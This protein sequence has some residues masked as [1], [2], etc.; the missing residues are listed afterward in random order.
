MACSGNLFLASVFDFHKNLLTI[1]QFGIPDFMK[2]YVFNLHEKTV[3]E[4]E[5]AFKNK[6]M[7]QSLYNSFNNIFQGCVNRELNSEN[8]TTDPDKFFSILKSFFEIDYKPSCKEWLIAI[9][10][11]YSIA[12][13]RNLNSRIA[14]A[15][16]FSTHQYDF[17][18]VI[19]G[20]NFCLDL[21]NGFDHHELIRKLSKLFK[22]S[23]KIQII[24]NPIQ[25]YCSMCTKYVKW[26]EC[27]NFL[28][29]ISDFI[30]NIILAYKLDLIFFRHYVVRFED[31]KLQTKETLLSLCDIIDIEWDDILLIAT[32]N[33]G[34]MVGVSGTKNYDTAPVKK[35]YLDFFSPFDWFR[36]ESVIYAYKDSPFAFYK[37][38]PL[39][40]KG[41]SLTIDE[42]LEIFKK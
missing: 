18:S 39:F 26:K 4:F 17:N 2:I 40:W 33:G 9:Y 28:N 7:P 6:E 13:N 30:F 3:E 12:L 24:R 15:I 31:L 32:D 5:T 34:E 11:A 38:K 36:I 8:P 20:K 10:L 41:E 37:Y 23:Y 14:P 29:L 16:L 35:L 1:R 27:R 21:G 22:Y 19:T 42:T 25:A